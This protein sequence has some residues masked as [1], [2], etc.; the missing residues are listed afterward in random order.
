M[1]QNIWNS[2]TKF[3][4]LIRILALYILNYA[5]VNFWS[6]ENFIANKIAICIYD[7]NILLKLS[8]K[9]IGKVTKCCM[10]KQKS[11]FLRITSKSIQSKLNV[12]YN[13]PSKIDPVSMLRITSLNFSLA[14][15]QIVRSIFC[16]FGSMRLHFE[17][18]ALISFH[19]L[20]FK[21]NLVFL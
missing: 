15:Q 13:V 5:H 3:S 9:Q 10:L 16:M 12:L 14:T 2:K 1:Q 11:I 4:F 8:E 18:E 17:Y 7:N 19:I 6:T 20:L 21:S